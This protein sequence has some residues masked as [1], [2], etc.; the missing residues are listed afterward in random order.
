V[1]TYNKCIDAD[2][3]ELNGSISYVGTSAGQDTVITATYNFNAKEAD[4]SSFSFKGVIA[5]TPSQNPAYNASDAGS[6]KIAINNFTVQYD[7]SVTTYKKGSYSF[8]LDGNKYTYKI[9]HEI[10]S[11]TFN[12]TVKAK[13]DANGFTGT[14]G[15]VTKGQDVEA[16]QEF[17]VYNPN[18]GSMTITYPDGT[19]GLLT[20]NPDTK[21]YTLGIDGTTTIEKWT[22]TDLIDGE[23]GTGSTRASEPGSQTTVD[24]DT[25]AGSA[26]QTYSDT[27]TGSTSQATTDSDTSTGSSADQSS[28]DNET[29]ADQ[30]ST[31]TE[32][33]TD[34]N[35]DNNPADQTDNNSDN[36]TE[37]QTDNGSDNTSNNELDLEDE[38]VV[39]FL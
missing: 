30:A 17:T 24:S 16:Y 20:S 5:V 4:T 38:Y 37:D 12:G 2:G 26:G 32:D 23:S 21:T 25:S 39:F 8:V 19:T 1:T 31:K 36:E 14:H 11:D 13:T 34:T 35:S 22:W 15:Y 10:A 29:T 18:S 33:Q 28:T 27:S 6:L 9:D 7:R 3:N